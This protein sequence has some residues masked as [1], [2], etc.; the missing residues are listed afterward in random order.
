MIT[1]KKYKQKV[2]KNFRIQTVLEWVFQQ[3]NPCSSYFLLNYHVDE[4][5]KMTNWVKM[6]SKRGIKRSK[7]VYRGLK[8]LNGTNR[9]LGA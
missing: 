9:G 2:V 8:G 4:M 7:G 6:E 3:V 1:R 5:E